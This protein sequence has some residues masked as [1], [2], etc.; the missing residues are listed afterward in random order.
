MRQKE[1]EKENEG[2]TAKKKSTAATIPPD[3]SAHFPTVIRHPL[4]SC[5]FRKNLSTA[6]ILITQSLDLFLGLSV[7]F[8]CG[9]RAGPNCINRLGIDFVLYLLINNN[10]GPDS[11]PNR[12]NVTTSSQY[13]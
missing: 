11:T 8:V 4:P 7:I 13:K 10:F 9:D 6:P 1:I 12:R 2:I 5:T 3:Y